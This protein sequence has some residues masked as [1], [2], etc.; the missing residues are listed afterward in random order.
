MTRRIW[1]PV[2]SA[3]LVV[4][5]LGGDASRDEM[6]DAE[7][8]F[9]EAAPEA[10]MM[11]AKSPA[12]PPVEAPSRRSRVE[13]AQPAV[14]VPQQRKIIRHGNMSIEVESVENAL[15]LIKRWVDSMGG[16]V[17]NESMS[18]DNYGRK[19]G[20]IACRIP[21]GEL[22]G[23]MERLKEL[24]EVEDVSVSAD[25]ITDQYY[26]LEIR[27]E[28]QK[29]LEKRLL[30]LLNRQTN[31]LSDL[32]EVEREL[33]RV[34]TQIDSMEGRKR[35]WDNQIAYSTLYVNV[36]EPMPTVAG[37]EGGA[38]RT[39]MRSFGEAADNF[40]L[41]IAGIISAS[42]AIVPLIV[43]VVFVIWLMLKIWRRRKRAA[44]STAGSENE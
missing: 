2:L 6:L 44:S 32:L 20:S 25:D 8:A 5:C 38:F 7:T 28:N 12:S 3:V 14:P 37:E 19:T 27:M 23:A 4:S 31:K 1:I 18:E 43:V 26:D 35:L 24:G 30:D 11:V 22:D 10:G 40:V 17:S 13:S 36:H 9:S 16:Y 29:Q 39:L 34:R 21:T 41:T 33:A 42:G 15:E